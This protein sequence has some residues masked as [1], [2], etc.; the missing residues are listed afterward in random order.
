MTKYDLINKLVDTLAL[1]RKDAERT[2]NTFFASIIES[3]S[4]GDG[5]GVA[6]IRES[7]ASKAK[8][9]K[10]A[11]SKNRRVGSGSSQNHCIF[12]GWQGTE[13]T[14][15]TPFPERPYPVKCDPDQNDGSGSAL[16][17]DENTGNGR[18]S[19]KK[20]LIIVF[21]FAG[22]LAFAGNDSP[23]IAIIEFPCDETYL[24]H[25][26]Q[27]HKQEISNSLV[28]M[29]TTELV[30]KGTVRVFE[31]GAAPGDPQRTKSR[32]FGEY[33]TRDRR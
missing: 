21:L 31:R 5:V 2:V 19:M 3:L 12:Q 7:P 24:W 13:A 28:D 4:G 14:R 20:M 8:P 15:S 26:F 23:R 27:G 10:R 6:G 33:H 22:M 11:Q 18:L 16:Y 1:N 25:G 17:V 29:F 9:E 32:S 30:S